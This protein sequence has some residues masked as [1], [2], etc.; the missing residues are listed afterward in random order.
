[1]TTISPI[2]GLDA[3]LTDVEKRGTIWYELT[4][5]AFPL[6]GLA[7]LIDDIRTELEDGRGLVKFT[8]LPEFD[9]CD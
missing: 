8:G 6:P 3:A 5:D 4:P 1:M 9:I 2:D 7:G